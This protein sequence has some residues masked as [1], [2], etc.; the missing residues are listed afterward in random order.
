MMYRY[1]KTAI[2]HRHMTSNDN[3]QVRAAVKGVEFRCFEQT[4]KVKGQTAILE[5]ASGSTTA[6]TLQPDNPVVKEM[7]SKDI[8][9]FDGQKY[10]VVSL[11]EVRS[12]A[13]RDAREY[14]IGLH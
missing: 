6:L 10:K 1:N 2:W 8:V 13:F 9:E 7:K 11:G 12:L 3:E 5:G 14:L 4:L